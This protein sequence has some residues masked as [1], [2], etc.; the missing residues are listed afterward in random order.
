[1]VL[2]FLHQ[3]LQQGLI[4]IE[5][6]LLGG[7]EGLDVGFGLDSLEVGLGP[8]VRG[9]GGGRFLL[10]DLVLE[11]LLN[12]RTLQRV[13]WLLALFQDLHPSLQEDQSQTQDP[14]RLIQQLRVGDQVHQ[15]LPLE[16]GLGEEAPH[17]LYRRQ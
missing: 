13:R 12:E 9:G 3:I 17:L 8:L 15:D 11:E 1:V 4:L 5:D 14:S 7:E 2:D 10:L 6:E 16:E